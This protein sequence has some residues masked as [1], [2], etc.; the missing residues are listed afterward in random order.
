MNANTDLS[1]RD[2]LQSTSALFIAFSMADAGAAMAAAVTDGKPPLLP[3]ELDSWISISKEGMVTIYFG[4]IDGGQGTDLAMAMIVA[5]EMDVPLKNIIV[6]QGDT[7]RTVN[8][9]GASGSTGAAAAADYVRDM[10]IPTLNPFPT[11]W[12]NSSEAPLLMT[13]TPSPK[14]LMAVVFNTPP[15]I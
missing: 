12:L 6:V 13:A 5:E 11:G 3:T 2:V 10:G 14:A 8:Q 1:R 15:L 4:K 9:G 7:A